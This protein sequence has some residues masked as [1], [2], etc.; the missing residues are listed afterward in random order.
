MIEDDFRRRENFRR[1]R[2]GRANE[3]KTPPFHLLEYQILICVV[4]VAVVL[5]IRATGG[6][7][8]D[9]VRSGIY[10]AFNKGVTRSDFA[11][12]FK[13]IKD[14]LP[15]ASGIF[16]GSSSGS[17]ASGSTSDTS[18]GLNSA[19]SNSSAASSSSPVSSSGSAAKSSGVD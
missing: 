17:S 10:D 9:A 7:V 19:S 18:S 15:D 13:N 1:T 8:Y 12:V 16:G 11:A 4:S 2:R 5:I 6:G 14:N 3:K